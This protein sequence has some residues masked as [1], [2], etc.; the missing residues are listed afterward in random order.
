MCEEK[1]IWKGLRNE[2]L[3]QGA[4]KLDETIELIEIEKRKL[5]WFY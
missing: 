2:E 1:E 4:K 5:K 3:K